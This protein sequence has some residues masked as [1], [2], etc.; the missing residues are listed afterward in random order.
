M[1]QSCCGELAYWKITYYKKFSYSSIFLV[2]E[3]G[4]L[5]VCETNHW[6]FWSC[7]IMS[8]QSNFMTLN[9]DFSY[10]LLYGRPHYSN[11]N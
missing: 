10:S 9:Q 8:S 6:N 7:S 4:F 2:C 5:C 3:G 11:I 1:I